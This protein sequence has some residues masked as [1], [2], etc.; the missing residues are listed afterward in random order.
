VQPG[1]EVRDPGHSAQT[2]SQQ[3]TGRSR[4]N[5]QAGGNPDP[6]PEDARKAT[7][8][9]REAQDELDH[10]GG[11]QNGPGQQQSRHNTAGETTR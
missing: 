8:E 7:E 2:H 10:Q 11:D 5:Q 6:H 1:F 9:Q 4:V 3:P